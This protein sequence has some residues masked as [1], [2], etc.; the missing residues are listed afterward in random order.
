MVEQS[1]LIQLIQFVGLITPALAIL[2]ELLIRFHGGIDSLQESRDIPIEIQVL[3]VGFSAIL[4]GGMGIGFQ[5]ITKLDN[6]M[7]QI[8]SFLIFGGLPF[9]ALSVLSMHIRI[10]VVPNSDVSLISG[11]ITGLKR[12]SSVGIPL[13]L[14]LLL[15]FGP[16]SFF[17]AE[18]SNLVGWW[19]FEETIHAKFYF[20]VIGVLLAYNVMYSLWS[21]ECIPTEKFGNVLEE[22]FVASFTFGAFFVF[23]SGPVFAVY[24][25]LLYFEILSLTPQSVF[26]SI[27]F[28]WGGFVVLAAL[29]ADLDPSQD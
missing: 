12:S 4:L 21:S 8:S 29:I 19:M 13:I 7:T 9:L 20:Y 22:W 18:I 14:T 23:L 2:I 17:Q 6:T 11:F 24:Y 5:M 3:F 28:I 25:G 16:V 27:P 10:S 26:S 1:T 15:Y